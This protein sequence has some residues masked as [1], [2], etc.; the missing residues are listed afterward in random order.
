MQYDGEKTENIGLYTHQR[1]RDYELRTFAYIGTL[2]LR[3]LS[4]LALM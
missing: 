1:A 2:S 4:L 3:A